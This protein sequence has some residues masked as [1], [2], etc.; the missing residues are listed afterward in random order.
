MTGVEEQKT[1]LLEARAWGRR[2]GRRSLS[3]EGVEATRLVVRCTLLLPVSTDLE[4]RDAGAQTSTDLV[5]DPGS[6]RLRRRW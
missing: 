2:D 3:V 1:S 6:W 4:L 5:A